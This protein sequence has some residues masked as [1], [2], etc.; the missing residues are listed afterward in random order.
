M[1]LRKLEIGVKDHDEPGKFAGA[2]P[3]DPFD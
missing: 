3:Q 1:R 2:A